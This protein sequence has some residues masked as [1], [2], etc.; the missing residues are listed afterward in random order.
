MTGPPS[1]A[2]LAEVAPGI[3]VRQGV[4]EDAT[5]ANS[6]AIANI[7]GSYWVPGW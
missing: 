3:H 4:T 1:A 5:A 6:D 2:R 7:G